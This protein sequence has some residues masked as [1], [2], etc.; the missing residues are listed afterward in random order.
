[1]SMKTILSFAGVLALSACGP[2]VQVGGNAPAPESLLT[3]TANAAPAASVSGAPLLIAT[4]SVPGKLKTLRIPVTTSA[5]EV[6]YLGAA[7]WLEQP[8]QLFHQILIDTY[9]SR[10]GRPAIDE[11]NVDISPAARLS[12]DLLEFGLDVTAGSMVRVRYD[13]TL[14]SFS[15]GLLATRRFET[16]EPVAAETGP[17]VADALGRAA[18]RIAADVADWAAAAGTS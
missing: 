2:L 9:E 5:N 8:N 17:L 1:M 14:T 3:V 13:A 7:S 4:P 18:N 15:G 6:K 11:R 12:G 16:T 10:S